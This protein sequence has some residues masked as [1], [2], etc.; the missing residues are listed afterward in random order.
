MFVFIYSSI[1]P[2]CKCIIYTKITCNTR[3]HKTE[4]KTINK[5]Y[6]RNPDD[7]NVNKS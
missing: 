7:S 2:T 3:K 4:S 5:R 6:N 1:I